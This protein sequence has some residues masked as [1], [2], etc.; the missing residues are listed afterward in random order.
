MLFRDGKVSTRRHHSDNNARIVLK[1][2]PAPK[3]KWYCKMASNGSPSS[4]QLTYLA[5]SVVSS[6]YRNGK[7]F[8]RR[9]PA[10]NDDGYHG[11][12]MEHRQ[13]VINDAR[14]HDLDQSR[15]QLNVRGFELL[16][17]PLQRPE[18]PFFDSRKVVEE[19]YPECADIVKQ[20]TNAA[21]VFAF[22]HNVR[23]A[24]EIKGTK[25]IAGG[26]GIQKPIHVVHGDYTLTSAS[27]RLRDLARPPGVN[28]TLRVM[29]GKGQSLLNQEI[30][31]RTLDEGKR[32]ALINVWRSIDLSPVT[33]DPLALC[34]GRNVDPN[35][36][37][38]FE[39][40][41]HDRIG[42]NYFAK[43]GPQHDWWYY[44]L[45]TRDEVIL[46]KQWDS[47]GRFAQSNGLHADSDAVDGDA[48][49]TFSLHSAFSDPST[50]A[51][52]PKRQS[53]E[54]RCV[55]FF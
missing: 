33:S 42:E 36:L 26:Q 10:G 46:I 25:Q 2:E 19:Y 48:P 8:T 43:F 16:Y 18:T 34:D 45:M 30:V 50:P 14:Q 52:A 44:P 40:L 13:V 29:L 53:I 1:L 22:D 32:F 6:L 39:I 27:Q 7:V 38:V 24:Q 49:C 15:Q 47:A 55:A 37:V 11:A 31:S 54:V 28:D 17:R 9:D 20:T 21:Q 35:D 12:V 23:L 4:G 5:T 51:D 3:A 41:Y